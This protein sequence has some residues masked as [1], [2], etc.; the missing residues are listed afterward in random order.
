MSRER[1]IQ[2]T[3]YIG[4]KTEVKNMKNLIGEILE[5]NK[6]IESSTRGKS[7]LL[8]NAQLGQLKSIKGTEGELD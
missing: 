2:E 1:L 6:I 5:N 8:T 4:L 3:N 7:I